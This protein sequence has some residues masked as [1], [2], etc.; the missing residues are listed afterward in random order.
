MLVLTRR[1][2]EEIVIDGGIRI[3]VVSVKGNTVRIGITAP[4]VVAVDRQEVHQRRS[5]FA[6]EPTPPQPRRP[7]QP[8]ARVRVA[9]CRRSR[10][11]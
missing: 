9:P 3:S 6:E 2:N 8:Q 7:L 11:P 5:E 1:L 4:P 10:R